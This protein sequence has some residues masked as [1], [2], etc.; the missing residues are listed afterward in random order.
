MDVIPRRDAVRVVLRDR[1]RRATAPLTGG[2]PP[3]RS[4]RPPAEVTIISALT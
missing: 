2:A 3:C 1:A 4:Y